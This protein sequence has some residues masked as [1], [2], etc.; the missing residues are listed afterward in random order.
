MVDQLYSGYG[1]GAP[2]G[3][4]PAQGRIMAEGNEYLSKS[5]PKL[6]YIKKAEI[7]SE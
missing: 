6:D 3:R 7:I 2:Q 1:E 4:G 5:F